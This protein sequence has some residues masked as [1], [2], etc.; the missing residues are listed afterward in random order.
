M[1]LL[2]IPL[3]T[4]GSLAITGWTIIGWT[5]GTCFGLRWAVQVWHRK[6]TGSAVVPSSFWWISLAGGALTMA[7]FIIGHPDSVGVL[8]SVVPAALAGYNLWL[9]RGE[10]RR[11]AG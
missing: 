6:K 5:G 8:Q 3:L 11:A 2:H 9:D 10:R 7:Y 1:D 4:L